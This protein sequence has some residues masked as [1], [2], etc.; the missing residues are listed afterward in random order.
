MEIPEQHI[1]TWFI[2]LQDKNKLP[3]T[4]DCF[5]GIYWEDFEN[6]RG[7]SE[8]RIT[9]KWKNNEINAFSSDFFV[10]FEQIREKLANDSIYPLCYGASRNIIVTGMALSMGQGL[11]V[12]RVTPDGT[13]NWEELVS[14][15]E[16]G[17]DVEPVFPQEQHTFQQEFFDDYIDPKS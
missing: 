11:R 3:A 10:A 13:L 5:Q 15:F 8:C 12:Y 2:E 16:Y 4:I 17:D 1:G 6:K 14:I 9:L 7:Y